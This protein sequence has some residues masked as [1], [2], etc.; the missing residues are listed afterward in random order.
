MSQQ[1]A[2]QQQ[3]VVATASSGSRISGT[4]GASGSRPPRTLAASARLLGRLWRL[5]SSGR[6]SGNAAACSPAPA[7]AVVAN[8]TEATGPMGQQ[9]VA[10]EGTV[11]GAITAA[12]GMTAAAETGIMNAAAETETAETGLGTTTGTVAGTAGMNETGGSMSG[13]G[14]ASGVSGTI[15]EAAETTV[16]AVVAAA[17][18]G[19]QTA[20]ADGTQPHR[21]GKQMTQMAVGAP[22]LPAQAAAT[23]AALP[24]GTAGTLAPLLHPAPGRRWM[25][26][27]TAAAAE[28]EL[29]GA[30]LLGCRHGAVA[31]VPAPV[32]A[33]AAA[34]QA[35]QT[36][37]LLRGPVVPHQPVV[38]E[39][40]QQV[41]VASCRASAV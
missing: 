24:Y 22:H 11:T 9:S 25:A 3:L 35:R 7:T 23:P 19:K 5:Q 21:C 26:A 33:G 6:K 8:V 32:A 1:P 34:R 20:A 13:V 16:T 29:Q 37:Q 27:V 17:V 39:G 18:G 4:S 14:A 10:A 30:A 15:G 31:A 38:Q 12:A 2:K 40:Q 41:Q 36:C 28:Q